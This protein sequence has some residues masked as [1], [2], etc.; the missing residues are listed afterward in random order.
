VNFGAGLLC[1]SRNDFRRQF[2]RF[3]GQVVGPTA[4]A[5]PTPPSLAPSA[6]IGFGRASANRMFN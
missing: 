3:R 1:S 6:H 4:T 5:A 2:A